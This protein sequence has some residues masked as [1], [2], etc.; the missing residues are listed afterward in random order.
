MWSTGSWVGLEPEL[1]W[2]G[3][4]LHA[5]MFS[6]ICRA[7]VYL[8][9]FLSPKLQ[10][11]ELPGPPYNPKSGRSFGVLQLSLFFSP[12]GKRKRLQ[13]RPQQRGRRSNHRVGC[14]YVLPGCSSTALIS[15]IYRTH[16]IQSTHLLR[17]SARQ[18]HSL[19]IAVVSKIERTAVWGWKG[20]WKARTGREKKCSLLLLHMKSNY[21]SNVI[22]SFPFFHSIHPLQA[23]MTHLENEP[24]KVTNWLFNHS[25]QDNKPYALHLPAWQVWKS[26][27]YKY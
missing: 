24:Q 19:L 5:W 16:C 6:W 7:F 18:N 22:Y 1:L 4:S 21:L 12:S 15:P 3:F 10:C 9:M 25:L 11:V 14:F 27:L 26:E 8:P 17:T 2:L 20:V 23:W 13:P